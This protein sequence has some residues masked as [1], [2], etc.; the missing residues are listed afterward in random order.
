MAKAR[1]GKKTVIKVGIKKN[2]PVK[3]TVKKPVGKPPKQIKMLISLANMRS[4]W[5]MG[6]TYNVP[7][8]VSV[9]TAR[10]WV[11]CGVAEDVS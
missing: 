10:D 3:V 5:I 11:A 6:Q 8:D 9:N 7:A 1:T 4:S 2:E